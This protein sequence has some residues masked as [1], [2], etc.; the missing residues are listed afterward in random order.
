MI[1]DGLRQARALLDAGWCKGASAL[2][3]EGLA[4]WSDSKRAVCFCMLGA[5]NRAF[6]DGGQRDIAF[7]LIRPLIP[8]NFLGSIYGF[9]D[10]PKTTKAMVLATMDEAI[11][12]AP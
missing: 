6:P 4:C 3:A 12:V 1:K 9:N 2:D 5:I 10:D 7:K 8:A 11:E